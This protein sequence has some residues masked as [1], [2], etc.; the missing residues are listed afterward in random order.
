MGNEGGENKS[1]DK[2]AEKKRER[3]RELHTAADAVFEEVQT[4]CVHIHQHTKPI[5]GHDSLTPLQKSLTD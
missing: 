3:E 2:A 4:M 5:A 1:V